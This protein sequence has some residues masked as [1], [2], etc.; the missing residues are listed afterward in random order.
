MIPRFLCMR[1]FLPN[2]GVCAC[3]CVCVWRERFTLVSIFSCRRVLHFVHSD[4]VIPRKG[5]RRFARSGGGGKS[6]QTL[7]RL[8]T[9]G[10]GDGCCNR[11][12]DLADSEAIRS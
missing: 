1:C 6:V 12:L 9:S 10:R 5:D 8:A 11:A 4:G 2:V 7:P 3:G